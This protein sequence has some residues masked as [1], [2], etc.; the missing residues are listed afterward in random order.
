MGKEKSV[1]DLKLMATGRLKQVQDKLLEIYR[2]GFGYLK[3]IHLK[4]FFLKIPKFIIKNGK[5]MTH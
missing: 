2:S 3:N 5:T 1:S 4:T